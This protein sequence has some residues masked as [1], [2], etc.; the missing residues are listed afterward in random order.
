MHWTHGGARRNTGGLANTIS[1]TRLLS[2]RELEVLRLVAGGASN[3]QI[4]D[5]LALSVHTVKKH[6]AKLLLKLKVASRSEAALLYRDATGDTAAPAP[7]PDPALEGLTVRE[8][9]VLLRMAEGSNNQRIAAELALSVNTVKRHS[10][11]IFSK[12]G[13][14]SRVKAAA[15]LHLDAR[16][17]FEFA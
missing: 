2:P 17:R 1:V 4:A 5:A 15:L 6:V 8:R 10:T 14:R 12:L 16:G 11:K 7:A 3:V 13:V 9:D